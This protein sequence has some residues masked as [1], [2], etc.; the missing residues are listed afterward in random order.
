MFGENGLLGIT[1]VGG[2]WWESFVTA[3]IGL[4]PNCASSVVITTTFV[5]GGISFG[6]LLAGLIPNAGVGLAV[7]FRNTKKIKR[8][9]IILISLYALGAVCGLVTQFIMAAIF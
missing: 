8:N 7:L 9:I 3:A 4:I 1:V 5:Q 6:A 2:G